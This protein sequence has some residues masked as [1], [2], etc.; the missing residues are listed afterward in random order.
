MEDRSE[1]EGGGAAIWLTYGVTESVAIKLTGQWTGHGVDEP[2]EGEKDK[3]GDEPASGLL[4]VINVA[5]GLCYALDLLDFTPAIEAGIGVLHQ[6]LGDV[7][8]TELGVRLGISVDYW[9]LDWLSVGVA[10]HYHAFL[11]NLA[12]YPVYFDTGPR[13]TVRWP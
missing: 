6:R 4:H 7:S 3:K 12:E 8:S 13:V 1:P 2:E 9:L 10:F 11:T 5:A